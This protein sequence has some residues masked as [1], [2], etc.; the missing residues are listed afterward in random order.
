[1][2]DDTAREFLATRGRRKEPRPDEEIIGRK[3]GWVLTKVGGWST[4]PWVSCK[5][6]WTGEESR[7]KNL[8]YVGINVAV[9]RMGD[10][11]DTKRIRSNEPDLEQWLIDTA[12]EAGNG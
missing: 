5:L 8:Y 4:G 12:K 2:M 11:R 10:N 1:M 3:D 7:K 9:S 6:Y